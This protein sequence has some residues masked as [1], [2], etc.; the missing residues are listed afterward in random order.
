MEDLDTQMKYTKVWVKPNGPPISFDVI[1]PRKDN[2]IL[3][4]ILRQEKWKYVLLTHCYSHEY[5]WKPDCIG[6]FH[7]CLNLQEYAT[8]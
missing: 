6:D 8:I 5:S 4:M 2:N 1:A 7:S 3:V